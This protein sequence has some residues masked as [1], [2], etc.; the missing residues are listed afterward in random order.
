M[1]NP[2]RDPGSFRDPSGAVYLTDDG[3]Y[4]TIAPGAAIERYRAVRNAGLYSELADLGL[5]LPIE[6]T[7]RE[8]LAGADAPIA[9]LI[10]APRLSLISY[11]YE[12]GFELHRKAA[13]HHLDL[14]LALL[15]RDFT[16]ADAS[17]YN[18]QF[19]GVRPV[20]IDHLSVRPYQP[21]EIWTG[22]RQF[23]M[24][25]LN[26]LLCHTA[27][28]MP[29]NV[30][31]RGNLEG[32]EPESLAPLLPRRKS[33]S[34]TILTHVLLQA[35]L[36]RRASVRQG[37]PTA[38]LKKV[39]LPKISMLGIL[40][41][42]RA[43]VSGMRSPYAKTTW[44]DYATANSYTDGAAQSKQ[45]FVSS[46]VAATQPAILWDLGCNTGDYSATALQSG[47]QSVFGFDFDHGALDLACARAEREK[48]RFL[49]LW[50]DAANPSPNQGW[51]QIERAGLMERANANALTALAFV[52]HLAITRNVPLE[53]VIDWIMKLAPVGIIEFPPKSDPMV[54]RLLAL[55]DDIFSDYNEQAFVSYISKRGRIV[56]QEFLDRNGRLLCWYDRS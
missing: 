50:L 43:F 16:L 15:E 10:R 12:W 18:I 11:P 44:S 9:C 55:R 25:F 56:K 52:H 2:V 46:M 7:D 26:P 48:L 5:I 31:F 21:G 29:P 54:R 30:W 23:C 53:A 33:F 32:I 4:R 47:A 42:L 49:P 6:E 28:R 37:A 35:K 17:A 8:I 51:A 3:A 40:R 38:R 14:H 34:W 24:Q 39:N 22:H 27:L 20:F 41:G 1:T 36:Q 19:D 45:S 13:L